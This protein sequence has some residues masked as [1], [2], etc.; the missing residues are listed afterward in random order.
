[1]S[2]DMYKVVAFSASAVA[3]FFLSRNFCRT[4]ESSSFL[5]L[6]LSGF[7]RHSLFYLQDI[8]TI[9]LIQYIIHVQHLSFCSSVKQQTIL[10]TDESTHKNRAGFLPSHSSAK[11]IRKPKPR[12]W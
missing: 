5:Y 4:V 2:A 8:L 9:F 3:A 12:V 6:L 10:N 7:T 11:C 1:M